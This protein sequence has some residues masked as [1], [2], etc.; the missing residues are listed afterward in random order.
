MER[1]LMTR[2]SLFL[3]ALFV[4]LLALLSC[5]KSAGN[6]F[7]V[8]PVSYMTSVNRIARP[9]HVLE[10]LELQAAL[11]EY[12][13]GTF[14]VRANQDIRAIEVELT[15]LV[16]NQTKQRI[17]KEVISLKYLDYNYMDSAHTTEVPLFL[18]DYKPLAMKAGEN[19]Q[20][21]ITLKVQNSAD[22]GTFTGEVIIKVSNRF[23]KLP[24]SFTVHPLRLMRPD[25]FVCGAFVSSL[26][27]INLSSAYDMKAHG[28]EAVQF[29]FGYDTTDEW[30]YASDTTRHI[31][32]I[33]G[34]LKM[35]FYAI[36]SLLGHM[37]KAG[38]R[39]PVI[40][41][42]GNDSKDHIARD[43]CLA[44]PG[45]HLDTTYNVDGKDKKMGPLNNPIFDTLLL[46]VV[47]QLKERIES[48]GFEMVLLV[49]DEP[50]ERLMKE[51]AYRH[52][53][54]HKAF[55]ALRIYGVT[56]NRLAWA[57]QVAPFSD[58]LVSNGSFKEISAY[59]RKAGK[60]A[61][62]YTF[63]GSMSNAGRSRARLGFRWMKYWPD[64]VWF[65]A[66]NY[67][68]KDPYKLYDGEEPEI[69]KAVV[70]PPCKRS[71]FQPVGTP[72]WEGIR[73]ACD[74]WA[75]AHTLRK[76]LAKTTSPSAKQIQK[77]FLAR[78]DTLEARLNK[79]GA[80][81]DCGLMDSTR[82]QIASWIQLL[83]KM[84]PH[85]FKQAGLLP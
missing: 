29:F 62:F 61:W 84:E 60:A 16:N 40:P 38:M 25:N 63:G 69:K 67:Y 36:D 53:L 77:A 43:I 49:Y 75:Y 35:E 78:L 76:M 58:I 85:K 47:R 12:E 34:H 10:R 71:N 18:W 3:I 20:Y 73:E 7:S 79:R 57:K 9:D 4:P 82:T 54:I 46:S 32:N 44:F 65:W 5:M 81:T 31:K 83:I 45:F 17:S 70:F 6:L 19:R 33:D 66:Y 59:A 56:M 72:A 51:L 52:K 74:D 27:S 21:W 26:K 11:G 80:I 22:T 39:G 2:K 14:V 24:I 30:I 28:I 13:T 68:E 50:T 8:I 37:K 48:Y 1:L 23:H 42:T 55:P 41:S 64:G 15:D